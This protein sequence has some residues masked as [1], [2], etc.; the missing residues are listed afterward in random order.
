MEA[1]D[2]LKETPGHC[3]HSPEVEYE[4]RGHFAHTGSP[5]LESVPGGQRVH[6]AD[7]ATEYEPAGQGLHD[8][9]DVVPDCVKYVPARQSAHNCC[10]EDSAKVP[11]EHFPHCGAPGIGFFV[12]GRQSV[13]ADTSVAPVALLNV[14]AAHEK[15]TRSEVAASDE[16]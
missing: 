1:S 12:P 6:K 10:P 14:P 11:G 4:P 3:R 9:P 15:H 8:E 13:H 2:K 7:P 5:S 16:L